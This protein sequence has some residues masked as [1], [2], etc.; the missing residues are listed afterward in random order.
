M[1]EWKTWRI[2]FS[3]TYFYNASKVDG[4]GLPVCIAFHK[5]YFVE[6]LQ[7]LN[8]IFDDL[9]TPTIH[10]YWY[11]FYDWSLFLVGWFTQRG[12]IPLIMARNKILDFELESKSDSVIWRVGYCFNQ[13]EWIQSFSRV[14]KFMHFEKTLLYKSTKVLCTKVIFTPKKPCL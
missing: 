1:W 9:A 11:T 8:S 2:F 7:R 14:K 12:D 3:F 4:R 5:F 6:P 13:D 10:A